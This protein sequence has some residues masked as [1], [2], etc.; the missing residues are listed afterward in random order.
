MALL[1]YRV[2]RDHGSLRRTHV[3]LAVNFRLPPKFCHGVWP[4]GAWIVRCK[5]V[6]DPMLIVHLANSGTA[7]HQRSRQKEPAKLAVCNRWV[8]C[9][10]SS[11]LPVVRSLLVNVFFALSVSKNPEHLLLFAAGN[12]GDPEDESRTS[13]TI[14]I[15]AIGKNVLAV[16]ASSSGPTRRP[17]TASDG[18]I[19]S[20]YGTDDFS[21]IDTVA[22][23]SSYGLTRDGRIKPEVVAPG[24]QVRTEFV[25]PTVF[26]ICR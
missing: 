25:G 8:R 6:G 20:S 21:D 26:G 18:D 3:C 17:V 22:F 19:I 15:P 16:G 23:F 1:R 4:L 24:D 5:N 13:C 7:E 9:V 12:D 11:H 10:Q 14:N 2:Q